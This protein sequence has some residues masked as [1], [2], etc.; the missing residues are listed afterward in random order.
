[1]CCYFS[2]GYYIYIETSSPRVTG[3]KARLISHQFNPTR[4]S[5]CFTFWYHMCGQSIGSLN[6]Y[7]LVGQTETLIWTQWGNKGNSWLS[8]QVPVGN[9]TGYKVRENGLLAMALLELAFFC[10]VD[11]LFL[12][13]GWGDS[14]ERGDNGGR[15]LNFLPLIPFSPSKILT[16]ALLSISHL[17]TIFNCKILCNVGLFFLL[18][19]HIPT[20]W[21]GVFLPHTLPPSLLVVPSY[22][23]PLNE[24]KSL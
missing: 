24:E 10:P 3:D 22:P 1:M 9:V 5:S 19:L 21:S 2:Q 20:V 23:S 17:F 18:F 6:L 8:G 14:C 13:R 4:S 16:P 7:Q 15:G 11:G 12:N